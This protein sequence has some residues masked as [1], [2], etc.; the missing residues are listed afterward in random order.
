MNTMHTFT[1]PEYDKIR[2]ELLSGNI[3]ISMSDQ[4][5]DIKIK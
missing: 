4:K 1:N 2:E 5:N 3:L